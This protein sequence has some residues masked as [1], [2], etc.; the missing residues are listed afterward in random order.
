MSNDKASYRYKRLVAA[1]RADKSV[2]PTQVADLVRGQNR[3]ASA[4]LLRFRERSS[5]VV[6]SR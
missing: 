1:C 3:L 5:D 6:E 4:L 2:R